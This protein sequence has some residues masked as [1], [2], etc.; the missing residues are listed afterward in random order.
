M[1]VAYILCV[2]DVGKEKDVQKKLKGFEEVKEAYVVYGEYDLV[3]KLE[4]DD[5]KKLDAFIT[6]RIRGI[7]DIEMTSTMIAL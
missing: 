5:L 6:D 4:L 7:D 3:V 2:T 1:T